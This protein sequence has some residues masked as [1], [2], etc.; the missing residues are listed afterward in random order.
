MCTF[1]SQRI[2]ERVRVERY[3]PKNVQVGL[4]PRPM[5]KWVKE[6]E[7]ASGLLDNR[8]PVTSTRVRMF[9]IHDVRCCSLITEIERFNKRVGGEHTM[10][11]HLTANYSPTQFS[12]LMRIHLIEINLSKLLKKS[13]RN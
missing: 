2:L 11:R 7:P 10:K 9:R 6:F 4:L 8:N 1:V 3:R 5:S 12:Y 13:V